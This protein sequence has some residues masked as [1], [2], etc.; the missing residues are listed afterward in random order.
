MNMPEFL[1]R[2]KK[3]WSRQ[4][5][6]HKLVIV[7]SA[8]F[9][10]IAAYYMALHRVFFTPDQF[11]VLALIVV[12][13][14][15]Q[16]SSF[17]L[18]WTPLLL[19]ILSYEYLRG[20]IP[21][22]NPHVHYTLMPRFDLLILGHIPGNVLQHWLYSANHLHWY[23]YISVLLY[24]S[25]FIV[26]MI[27]GFIFWQLDRG[28]FRQYAAGIVLLSYVTFLTYLVFPA[29]PPWLASQLGV[30][31][32]VTHI[33]NEIVGHLFNY[34]AFPS[35]YRFFGINL[36]AA[37]PSLHAAYPLLTALFIY[38]KYPKFLP[39]LVLYVAGVWFAV[40]YLGEH[41][42]FDVVLGAT[43]ALAVYAAIERARG[44]LLRKRQPTTAT[45][46]V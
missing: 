15:G 19:L 37:V 46:P 18:D 17:I 10:S 13:G 32:P 6:Y 9:L 1:G 8:L 12:I 44:Y 7:C 29:A 24:L 35:V 22:I 21:S 42:L 40:M 14:T 34:V 3:H 43:Y 16:V 4:G 45:A 2:I 41:Y 23:D 25:H 28:F 38:K 11:Y 27:V 39:L 30:I 20:L 5:L 33:T 36:T 26:P 31:P